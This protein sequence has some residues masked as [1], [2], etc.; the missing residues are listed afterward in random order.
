MSV[1]PPTQPPTQPPSQPRSPSPTSTLAALNAP[2]E[3]ETSAPAAAPPKPD[4]KASAARLRKCFRCSLV[5]FARRWSSFDKDKSGTI[6]KNEFRSAL[7]SMCVPGADDA[8]AVDALFG[9]ID[10]D[11]SGALSYTEIVRFTLLEIVSGSM[12]RLNSLFKLLDSDASGTIDC[13]EFRGAIRTIGFEVPRAAV[14]M[15]CKCL[16]ALIQL[17]PERSPALLSHACLRVRSQRAR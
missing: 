17:R 11:S 10:F 2:P 12:T 13:D 3:R 6:G 4:D 1:R 5:P 16:G 9:D 15:L 14:V 7:L 8:T